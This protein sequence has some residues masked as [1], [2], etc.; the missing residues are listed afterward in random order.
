MLESDERKQLE[1][2]VKYFELLKKL[3]LQGKLSLE[4][5]EALIVNEVEDITDVDIS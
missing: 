5:L 4:E 3:Y 2:R 1:L